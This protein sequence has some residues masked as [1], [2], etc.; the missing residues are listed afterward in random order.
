MSADYQNFSLYSGETRNIISNI[1][2]QDGITPVDL[3]GAT[4]TWYLKNSKHSSTNLVTKNNPPIIISGNQITIP[5]HAADTSTLRGNYYHYCEMTD[6]LGNSS[7]VFTGY[8]T[9]E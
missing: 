8:M 5:L 3:T 2:E 9:V 7:V 4:V 6:A 1:T